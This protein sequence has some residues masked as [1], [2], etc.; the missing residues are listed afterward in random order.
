MRNRNGTSACKA[1]EGV[2]TSKMIL[3]PQMEL[4]LARHLTDLAN[5]FHGLTSTKCRELAYEFA[6]Q[7]G[8]SIPVSW[9]A[10][11]KAGVEWC[12]SFR[13]RQKL[14]IRSP[15]ATSF[16]RATA[17]NKPNIA[18]FFDNLAS[19]MDKHKFAA[20]QIFNLDETG[21]TTVQTPKAV[22]APTGQKQVGSI[23]SAERGELVSLIYAI[24]ASGAIVPPMIVFPRVN[25]RDHMMNGA[26]PSSVGSATVT[27]WSNEEI[28]IKYL[29]HFIAHVKCSTTDKVLVIMDN[30]DS[31]VTL[32][33]I[34]LAKKN[35]IVLLTLPPH[36]SHRL[37]P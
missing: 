2:K 32:E 31:H 37:Q 30:H 3:S 28:F 22:I 36:T 6:I 1:Y 33:A 16:A 29:N 7:N 10:N 5:M 8:T 24:T 14:S 4:E 21:V 9:A 13:V 17:F 19:V 12:K 11:K 34:D 26:P 23:T 35:G 18:K 27:G 20:H 25:F 15:E